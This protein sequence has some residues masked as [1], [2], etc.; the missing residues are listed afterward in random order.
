M[1]KTERILDE[2]SKP[3]DIHNLSDEELETLAEE[4]REEIINVTSTNGGHIAPS[5]GAVDLILAAHSVM[6][7]P[8]DKLLFDVGHQAYAHM[9]LCDKLGFK[10]LRTFEG[11]PGFPRPTQSE[12]NSNVA[13]HASDSLSVAAGYAMAAAGDGPCEQRGTV[14]G[15][16]D[17]PSA[18]PEQRGTVLGTGDGPCTSARAAGDGPC[19][20]PRAAGD[21]PLIVTIIG[22]A[23]IEGGM[24]L[25]ALNYIGSNQL[26]MIIILNDNAMAISPS[27]GAI[28]RHLSNV[29]T[30]RNYRDARV[31]MKK[32]LQDQGEIGKRAASFVSRAKTSFKTLLMPQSMMFEK[33]GIMCTPPI[34]GNNIAEVRDMI[35]IVKDV[36]GPVLIHAI[37]KKGKGYAPAERDPEGFHGVG[38]FE[39]PTG[40]AL[41]RISTKWTDVFGDELVKIAKDDDRIF[42]ITAAMEGGCGLKSFHKNF[43]ARFCDVG[44]AEENAVGIASG[45]A[46]AG[47]IP[48]VCI[49]STFLQRAVDQMMIDVCLENKNVVFAID[50]AGLV[51]D[52]GP[53][54]HGEFDI[55]YLRMMPNTTILTPSDETELRLALRFAINAEGPVA[56]R[57]P[58][59][60][61]PHYD[62]EHPAY[63]LGKSRVVKNGEDVAILSFG[64]MTKIAVD[65]S[66]LIEQRGRSCKVVDM[67]FA[68][69]LD[70]DQLKSVANAKVVATIEDGV[71][72]GGAGEGSSPLLSALGFKGKILNFAIDNKFVEHGT[73]DELF[74]SLGL[75]CESVATKILES[76]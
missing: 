15:T 10:T 11:Q 45:L 50:R 55:A 5:L 64:R 43:P 48:I 30:S 29:R 49:Y 42:A 28:T 53:T 74:T 31:S 1:S 72:Q 41:Q 2:I 69:P 23:A 38:K 67:R 57:Y 58:R 54:H 36:D 24:A 76:L 40:K 4:I 37:T 52:D 46:Y 18:Q 63:E 21:G 59:G 22:D 39:I 20:S 61:C 65:A 66:K 32:R 47:K 17:G 8:H 25:E 56:I 3:S 19:M 62:A 7:V 33:M 12:Y 34:D 9:I 26:K 13:G 60:E 71:L 6:N 75:D 51:G 73:V 44:I 68:K 70:L 35:N 14:L 16:G 27:V